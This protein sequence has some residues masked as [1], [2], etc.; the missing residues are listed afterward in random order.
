[1]SRGVGPRSRRAVRR[2]PS[3]GLLSWALSLPARMHVRWL[4]ILVVTAAAMGA[5]GHVLLTASP[6]PPGRAP[7]AGTAHN[8][9]PAATSPPPTP[10]AEH[11]P[12]PTAETSRSPVVG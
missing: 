2:P 10:T 4:V 7:S 3:G 6:M 12:K 8:Y 11:R 9:P 5:Y 1:M